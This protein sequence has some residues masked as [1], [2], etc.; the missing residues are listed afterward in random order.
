MRKTRPEQISR[1]L[2]VIMIALLLLSSVS[3][4]STN[5]RSETIIVGGA[6]TSSSHVSLTDSFDLNNI[7]TAGL[8]GS[9]I[10]FFAPVYE[11]NTVNGFQ[12]TV[13]HF[14][15]NANPVPT[16]KSGMLSDSFGNH[17]YRLE[18]DCNNYQGNKNIAVMTT[19]DVTSTGNPSPY[20]FTDPFPVNGAGQFVRSTSMVQ[21][22]HSEISA[23]S[24]ELTSGA[25]TE[26]EAVDRIMNFVR[27]SVSNDGSGTD[28]DAV[29]SLHSSTGNC[30]NRAN[31]ALALLRSSKIPARMVYGFV[32]DALYKI[33]MSDSSYGEFRWGKERH[34]WVEVY[35][36]AEDTWVPYDPYLNK[37]FVDHWHVK[38]GIG[39]DSDYENTATCGIIDMFKYEQ[40][41]GDVHG[42][43]HPVVIQF[44]SLSD[45]GSYTYRRLESTPPGIYVIGR[46][47][48]NRPTVTPTPRPNVTIT[49]TPPANATITPT[50]N[51]TVNVTPTT[52]PDVTVTPSPSPVPGDT[53][54]TGDINLSKYYVSTIVVDARTGAKITDANVTIDDMPLTVDSGGAYVLQVSKGNHTVS[55]TAPGYGNGSMEFTVEDRDIPIVLKMEPQ[56]QKAGTE[57]PG[58]CT[59]FPL[60][61]FEMIAAIA[62]ILIVARYRYGRT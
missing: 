54:N 53:G 20:A 59:P 52:V 19:F 61:G 7:N 60:P 24:A 15:I 10:I 41:N 17:Y 46:D 12:Q 36:A 25:T 22:D 44:T 1:P 45:S 4:F 32:N 50:P 5:V 30:V 31:L 8:N 23:K 13:T 56:Q 35:Y 11:T 21:S 40:M 47:M 57:T 26:A 2:S 42:Y 49:P 43:I 3:F 33:D 18:W 16:Y 58:T 37:G 6:V 48:F 39:L 14:Q 9:K 55:V 27:T 62:G 34:V 38:S 28:K 51:A 29:S